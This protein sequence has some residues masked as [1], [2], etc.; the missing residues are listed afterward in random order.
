MKVIFKKFKK[1]VFVTIAILTLIATSQLLTSIVNAEILDYLVKMDMNGFIRE[2]ILLV[3][4]FALYLLFTYMLIRYQAF[5]EQK[6]VTWLR[7]RISHAIKNTSYERFYE[8]NSQTYISWFTSDMEQIRT[9]AF[10]PTIEVVGGAISAVFSAVALFMY[11]WS[12]VLLTAFCIVLMA[13]LP[14]LFSGELTAKTM[15]TSEENEHFSKHVSDLLSGYDTLFVFRKLNYLTQKIHER[16][17]KVGDTQR[18]FSKT[19]AKVAVSGGISNLFCQVSVF[20]LTGYLAYIGEVSI[21]SIIA[22]TGL[23]GIIFNVLGNISQKIGS[24]KSTAPLFE[25]YELLESAQNNENVDK[26]DSHTLIE[27]SDV[28]FNYGEKVILNHVSLGFNEGQK[29]AITGESGTGKSTLLNIIAAKLTE[30]L[31]EVKFAGVDVKKQSYDELYRQMVYIAQKPHIFTTSIRENVTLTEEYTDEEVW[32]SLEK[33]GLATIVRNLPQGLDTVLGDGDS[34]LSGGQLQ[35]IAFARGLIKQPKVFLLDE[36]SSNLDE[37][38]TIEVLKPILEDKSVTVLW[39]THHL[40]EALKENIDKTI[41]M[42]EL[43]QTA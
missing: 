24:I 19:M 36:V 21:G 27:V 31:G 37:K 34:N 40:P 33:V 30:N 9:K 38:T 22:T 6:V 29:Y 41:Q 17:V 1:E 18:D 32:A 25:K 16:S 42:S 8:K 13:V 2:T 23:S 5:F 35:R 20:V 39:V 12:I 28:S 4:I 26:E 43:N 11:H 15:K 14:A 10:T 3:A 7:D